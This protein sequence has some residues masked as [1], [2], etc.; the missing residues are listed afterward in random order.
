MFKKLGPSQK[1]LRRP[2][3][4]KLVTGL[5][6]THVHSFAS[7]DRLQNLQF[8]SRLFYCW[9]LGL[10]RNDNINMATN[11]KRCYGSKRFDACDCCLW[12]QISLARNAAWQWLP[13]AISRP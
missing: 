11:L 8:S 12:T 1:T 4:P 5:S 9:S 6:P 13:I 2:W 7:R 3:C 10:L